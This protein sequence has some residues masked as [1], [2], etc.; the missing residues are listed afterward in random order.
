MGN[1]M[2]TI[3][4]M[5]FIKC[6]IDKVKINICDWPFKGIV[7]RRSK[8][9]PGS[10]LRQEKAQLSFLHSYQSPAAKRTAWSFE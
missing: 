2:P 9:Q 3:I 10:H 8:R 6:K 4:L 1:S 5:P 7:K